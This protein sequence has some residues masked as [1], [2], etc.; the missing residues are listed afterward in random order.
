MSE[1]A[2]GAQAERDALEAAL[3]ANPG[4]ASTHVK[5]A[6]LEA[7]L[8]ASEPSGPHLTHVVAHLDLCL[9]TLPPQNHQQVFQFATQLQKRGA[10]VGAAV[11]AGDYPRLMALLSGKPV[12]AGSPPAAQTTP[13]PPAKAETEPSESASPDRSVAARAE[14]AVSETPAVPETPAPAPKTRTPARETSAPTPQDSNGASAQADRSPQA[15]PPRVSRPAQTSSP[16]LSRSHPGRIFEEVRISEVSN[17]QIKQWFEGEQY[18]ELASAYP[19]IDNFSIR[20]R[21]VDQA[22]SEPSVDRLGCLVHMLS[23]EHEEK[24]RAYVIRRIVGFGNEMV[25]SNLAY[26]PHDR[27]YREAVIAIF[28]SLN[29]PEVIRPLSA[30]MRDREAEIRRIAIQGLIRM[31]RPCP[32]WIKELARAVKTDSDDR[33]RLYAVRAIKAIDTDEAFQ[34]LS[35]VAKEVELD[36]YC[37]KIYDDMHAKHMTGALQEQ[38]ARA[39]DLEDEAE[40]AKAKA[41]G[42]SGSMKMVGIVLLVAVLGAAGLFYYK[43]MAGGSSMRG[44]SEAEKKERQQQSILEF[45]EAEQR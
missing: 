21:I 8:W 24:D 1:V 36:K 41:K 26:D 6:Q 27:R 30:A 34:A 11:K 5:M 18:R 32:E 20:R 42:G 2:Q 28:A 10:P 40:K 17:P 38:R 9:A 12:P 33:V 23:Y 43:N 39:Q 35:Q 25:L 31:T 14:P 45:I 44:L 37:T 7:R 15:P 16:N 3:R 19:L 13:P 4:D 29:S 22:S